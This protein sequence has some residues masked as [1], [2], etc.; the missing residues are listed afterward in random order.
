MQVW[1]VTFNDE[2]VADWEGIYQKGL[3]LVDPESRQRLQRF[4]HRKD[5]FR[6]LVGRLLPRMLLKE[7]GVPPDRMSFGKTATGKPYITTDHL[8]E[9]IGYSITH[10]SGLIAMAF[11][12]GN[13]LYHD[14]PAYRVGVDVMKLKPPKHETFRAFVDV[15]ND[16]LTSL[17]RDILLPPTASPPLSQEEA[18]RRFY[19]I[20]TLKE[21]YTKALGLGLGFDF[22]RIEYDVPRDIVRIDG[23]V[24]RGWEFIR[25]QLENT[26][27]DGCQEKYV[28]AAARYIGEAVLPVE[29]C[30]VHFRNAGSWLKVSDAIEFV[31]RAL[32]ELQ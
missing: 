3:E 12:S 24:P 15:F 5:S 17:E 28:G 30:V 20:W 9:P 22:K 29:E 11:A 26:L 10:D 23:V 19:L 31:E 1:V 25:F 18:F 13:D 6:G 14:P 2:A 32:R 7:R 4:Y 8:A 21:A 16:Q 27:D